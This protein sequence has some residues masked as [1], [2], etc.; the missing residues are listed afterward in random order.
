MWPVPVVPGIC[1][2]QFELERRRRACKQLFRG[3]QSDSCIYCGKLIKPDMGLHVTNYHLDLA[4][5]WCCPV[6]WCMQWKGMPQDCAARL[7]QA[8]TVPDTVRVA[9]LGKWFPPWT[10]SR[11]MWCEA[12][13]AHVSGVSTDIL[14][15][16]ERGA[17]LIHHYHVF[18][19][20][21]A[22]NS[23]RCHYIQAFVAQTEAEA[24]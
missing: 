20:G 13:Q 8:H 3:T 7:R 14:L 9:N 16:S 2:L 12:L 11:E 17:P 6:S 23:L 19:G 1:N 24:R 18:G 15:F 21:S 22:H 10:V 4:Q 5:L